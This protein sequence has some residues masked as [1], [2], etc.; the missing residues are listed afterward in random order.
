M[1]NQL[2]YAE[3]TNIGGRKVNEDSIGVINTAS[4]TDLYC[5][6]DWADMAWGILLPKWQ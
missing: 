3:I 4:R 5:A 6:T 2:T 1:R